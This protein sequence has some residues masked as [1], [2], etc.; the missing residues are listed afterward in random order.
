MPTTVHLTTAERRD[1]RAAAVI[2]RRN[3]KRKVSWTGL[4]RDVGLTGIRQILEEA[5]R[6]PASKDR[7]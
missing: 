3:T 6:E 5:G 2:H 1:A 4:L 7:E